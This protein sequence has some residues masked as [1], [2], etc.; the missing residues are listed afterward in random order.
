MIPLPF[1]PDKVRF[2]MELLPFAGM[3]NV[4]LRVYSGSMSA[5]EIKRAVLLQLFWL[6]AVTGLG[7]ALCRLAEKKITVQGG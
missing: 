6:V 5:G 7:K 3:Q 2:F 4:A 1:F